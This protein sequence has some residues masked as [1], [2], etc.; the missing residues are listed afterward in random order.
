[1]SDEGSHVAVANWDS[2]ESIQHPELT[3]RERQRVAT[4]FTEQKWDNVVWMPTW[5]LEDGGK[6]VETVESS[7]RLA[8]GDVADYSEKAWSFGQPHR[9]QPRTQYLP[10]SQVIVFERAGGVDEIETP[11]VGLTAF[12]G[13][14]DAP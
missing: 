10:K 13:G 8:V 6:D 4:I 5:L 3:D 1:M 7:T 12:D 14:D 2:I 11:Q 9:N